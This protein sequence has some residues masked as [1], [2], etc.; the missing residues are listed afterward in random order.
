VWPILELVYS[1][2]ELIAWLSRTKNIWNPLPPYFIRMVR[3]Q[4]HE[5]IDY[6]HD[7]SLMV[8]VVRRWFFDFQI[9]NQRHSDDKRL[10]DGRSAAEL[11][12]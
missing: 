5:S 1:I 8:A 6:L 3:V 10:A 2:Q 12:G 4:R 7:N 9:L 11:Q